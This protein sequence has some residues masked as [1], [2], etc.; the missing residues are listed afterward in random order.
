MYAQQKVT[1]VFESIGSATFESA[2]G[3][4]GKR[5]VSMET[6]RYAFG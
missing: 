6:R 2:E 5:R 1:H 3:A 4:K